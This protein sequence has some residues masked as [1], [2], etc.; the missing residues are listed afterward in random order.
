VIVAARQLRD[1][2]RSTL[3]WIGG[4]L[5]LVLFTVALY[6]STKG[7]SSFDQVIAD[8]PEGFKALIGYEAGVPLTSP[9]GYLHARLFAGLAPLVV[10]VFGIGAGAQAIG[11]SEDAGTLEPLLANPVTR[12]RVAAECYLAVVALLAV[13]V[14]VFTLALVAFGAPFGVLDGVS[15][16]PGPQ[17]ARGRT[18]GRRDRPAAGGVGAG[19]PGRLGGLPPPRPPLSVAVTARRTPSRSRHA[20]G[21]RPRRIGDRSAANGTAEGHGN[22][23]TNAGPEE[24]AIGHERPAAR[25]LASMAWRAVRYRCP[26]SSGATTTSRV[27]TTAQ[28]QRKAAG[29]RAGGRSMLSQ[30]TV[31]PTWSGRTIS[32][33]R[34]SMRC[35]R[36]ANPAATAAS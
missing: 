28:N 10:L 22:P 33:W 15:L 12:R 6:P 3:W 30:V 16:V 11:G 5:A 14:A 23:V 17:H 1:R 2:R 29:S 8:L 35:C 13:L 9:P 18:R 34:R 21:A 25:W 4:L 32:A 24:A 26:S 27:S 20:R 31:S 19:R 36:R 7:Q